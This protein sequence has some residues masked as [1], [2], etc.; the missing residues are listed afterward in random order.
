[1]AQWVK[2]LA[3]KSYDLSSTLGSHVVERENKL[4]QDMAFLL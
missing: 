3:T 1:M 2:T 4:L